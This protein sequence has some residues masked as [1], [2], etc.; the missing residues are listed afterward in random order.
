M[1]SGPNIIAALAKSGHLSD[2]GAANIQDGV[3]A[4]C[5]TAS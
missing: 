2:L 5:L 4:P 3:T 1:I